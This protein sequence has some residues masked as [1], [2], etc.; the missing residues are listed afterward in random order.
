M[1]TKFEIKGF[2]CFRDL[3]INHLERINLFTGTN[4]IG[5]TALLEAIFLHQGIENPELPMRFNILR[6]IDRFSVKAE[7]MWGWLFP[8]RTFDRP[9]ELSSIDD[10][11]IQ[12]SAKLNLIDIKDTVQIPSM[13]EHAPS[14]VSGYISSASRKGG[15]AIEYQDSSGRSSKIEVSIT[16]V[17]TDVKLQYRRIAGQQINMPLSIYLSSNRIF[18][19]ENVERFSI[20]EKYGRQEQILKP[21]QLLEPRLKKLSLLVVGGVPV[22]HGDIGLG[23][24][25]PLPMMGDGISRLLFALLAI[26]NAPGGVVLLDEIENG[27]YH[28][29]LGAV[30][31][32]LADA[33]RRSNVQLFITTHSWECIKEA[34]ESFAQENNYDFALHRL[35]Q[36]AFE[37]KVVTYDRETLAN[38]VKMN[39]EV[40]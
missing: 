2:R 11:G 15:L 22:I 36:K 4:N 1:Y 12:R 25:I 35:E 9:I 5:K 37:I 24:L 29:T 30:W 39:L 10:T 23:E 13:D 17:G 31:K 19:A 18:H 27:L 32:V 6:G 26:A 21:L 33:A 14:G 34:H 40:R 7:E 28:S 20:I 38:S 8:D 3:E 16:S